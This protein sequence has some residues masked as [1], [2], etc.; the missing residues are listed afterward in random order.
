MNT[1]AKLTLERF[2]SG[3]VKHSLFNWQRVWGVCNENKFLLFTSIKG[4]EFHIKYSV[5]SKWFAFFVLSA[6][7]VVYKVIPWSFPV[8]FFY[9]VNVLVIVHNTVD[10]I[11][12]FYWNTFG[13][14][15]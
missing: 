7:K 1:T 11:S 4:F 2:T 5:C 13:V 15:L 3:S 6:G 14:P 10:N 9:N 12:V 8:T